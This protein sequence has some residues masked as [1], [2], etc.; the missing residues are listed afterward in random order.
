MAET[1]IIVPVPEAEPIVGRWRRRYTPSGAAGMPAHVTLLVPFI[2]SD[3]L[4]ADAIGGV[5]EVLARF[6]PV[7]LTL[8]AT[9]YFEGPPMVLY[10]EPVP[11][12]PFRAMTAALVSAFPEHPPYGGAH[13]RIVPHLTVAT[14][15]APERLAEIETEVAA[16]LP[17]SARPGEAWLMEYADEAWR[18]RNRFAFA[19][20]A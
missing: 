2:D 13:V 15:L 7:E 20:P 18:L 4:S 17:I 11:V 16:A 12:A 10:L 6:G 5:D 19:T 8:A 9:A 14:R 1:A 3:A